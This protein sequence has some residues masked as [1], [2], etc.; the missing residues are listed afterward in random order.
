MSNIR[1]LFLP[2]LVLVA[3]LSQFSIANVHAAAAPVLM[4]D[5]E[6]DGTDS[7]GNYNHGI[8]SGS[9][10]F[11]INGHSGK[12]LSLSGAG[13]IKLP[14]SI[15]V[16]NQ[17]FT[18]ALWFKTTSRG[19][20][21]GYQNVAVG[22]GTATNFIPIIVVTDTGYLRTEIWKNGGGSMIISSPSPVND[23]A[24]HRVV[25]TASTTTGTLAVYLDGVQ[26]GTQT[27]TVD[28]LDM[29]FN[30]IG[31]VDGR[32]RT[33][34][35]NGWDYFTGHIDEFIFY[36]EAQT[37]T[38]IAKITQSI[39]FPSPEDKFLSGNTAAVSATASSSLPVSFSSNTA[40]ICTVSGT[41]VTFLASGQCRIAANQAGDA[42][43]SPAAQVVRG[44]VVTEKTLVW[45]GL[46]LRS[47]AFAAADS[48]LYTS[49][50]QTNAE[51]VAVDL[52]E[53]GFMDVI[54]ADEAN[55]SIIWFKNVDG[56]TIQRIVISSGAADGAH[57]IDVADLDNDGDLDIASVSWID[58]E[59]AWYEN[60]G[61]ENFTR[62]ITQTATGQ[63]PVDIS[64]ADIDGD[65]W[66]DFVLA[67]EVG[68][69][70]ALHYNCQDVNAAAPCV[71]GFG[72]GNAAGGAGYRGP[73]S[74]P[75]VGSAN[76]ARGVVPVDLDG[77][78]KLDVVA[79]LDVGNQL[80]VYEQNDLDGSGYITW[81]KHIVAT[82]GTAG[83]DV[84][85]ADLDN[86]GDL[87]IIVP[88]KTSAVGSLV[89]YENDA[90]KTLSD[91]GKFT[92]HGVN[93]VARSYVQANVGDADGDG[94]NDILSGVSVGNNHYLYVNDGY[95]NF[96][97]QVVN[98]G[99]GVAKNAVL[100]D[101]DRDGDADVFTSAS[102]R[103]AWVENT[104]HYIAL[105]LMERTTGVGTLLAIDDNG[106]PVT[107]AITGGADSG[108]MSVNVN[109][110]ALSFN[111]APTYL[112]YGD[113]NGDNVYD[114]IVTAT[115]NGASVP[116]RVLVTVKPDTDSDGIP[117]DQDSD[118]D[119][120]GVSDVQEISD[121][122][123]PLDYHSVLDTDGDGVPDAHEGA[124][125]SG[126][127]PNAPDAVDSDGDGISDY[128]EAFP[129]AADA[130]V[131]LLGSNSTALDFN[132][133]DSYLAIAEDNGSLN[134]NAGNK[135]TVAAW[136]QADALGG[137][138]FMK[139]SGGNS[140]DISYT[141]RTGA[142][143]LKMEVG[144]GTNYAYCQIPL[145][146]GA[147]HHVVG[148]Y[149]GSGTPGIYIDGIA[150]AC[151]TSQAA[152]IS[153]LKNVTA[154]P[155]FG[156]FPGFGQYLD[157]RLDDVAIWNVQLN[158]AAIAAIYN[159]GHYVSTLTQNFLDYRS[160]ASL[161]AYW[162]FNEGSGT[163]TD[164]GSMFSNVG[165]LTNAPAWVNN[166]AHTLPVAENTTAVFDVDA[167][168]ADGDTLSFSIDSGADA[169]KFTINS[170]T[171]VLSFITAPDY[172][173][174]VDTGADNIY[175]LVIAVTA[176][177]DTVTAAVTVAVTDIDDTTDSDG[178]GLPDYYDPDDDN[179]GVPDAQEAIDGTD[180]LNKL[181]YKDSDGDY[182]P[183]FVETNNDFTNPND[184]ADYKDSD[185][186]G[187][188][189]QVEPD[190]CIFE[191]FS[192]AGTLDSSWQVLSGTTYTPNIITYN[193]E[194][195][196]RLTSTGTGLVSG[197]SKG[198]P[199][200]ATI[201]LRIE[202]K[203]ATYGGT[204]ADGMSVIL[205]NYAVSP[206]LGDSGG[207]LGYMG[208]TGFAGGWLGIG[209]SE[210]PSLFSNSVANA[211]ALRGSASTF[212][213]IAGTGT[214]SPTV[215]D[216]TG[217]HGYRIN[218]VPNSGATQA[219]IKVERDTG[220]GYGTLISAT[221]VLAAS[222]Q[223]ALPA[224]F[225]LSF[226]GSTGGSTN[227]HEITRLRVFAPG[228]ASLYSA[229]S[230]TGTVAALGDSNADFTVSLS[231][232]VGTGESVSVDYSTSN[233]DALA[234]SE[235]T[236]TSGTLTFAPGEQVKTVSV[237]LA[238]L[239]GDNGKKFY[240]QL[241]NQAG[242]NVTVYMGNANAAATIDTIDTD[243]D[244]IVNSLDNDDDNDGLS[245][246]LEATYGTDPLNTDTDGDG[247]SDS[248]EI[249]QGTDPLNAAPIIAQSAPLT[250]TMDED[251][252]PTAWSAPTVSATDTD[253]DILSWSVLH[254]P[255]HG[256]AS[257]SGSGASP[258]TFNYTPDADYSGTDYF[259]IVVTDGKDTDSITVKVTV[260]PM[261]DGAVSGFIPYT[262]GGKPVYDHEGSSD[263]T[264]GGAAVQP[265]AIDIASC[266]A[267]GA[268]P[269]TKPS[270][271]IAYRDTDK[272]YTTTGDAQLV[273]RMRLDTNPSE[274]GRNGSG[275]VS[276]HWDFLIDIDNDGSND[277]IIDVDGGYASNRLDRVVLYADNNHNL[278]IDGGEYVAE[279]P[280]AGTNASAAQQA[281]SAVTITEDASVTCGRSH[282]FWLDIAIPVDSFTAPA[283][284][285]SVPIGAF[286]STSASNTDPLQKDLMGVRDGTSDT[287][288]GLGGGRILPASGNITGTVYD[289]VDGNR[290]YDE[291]NPDSAL[292]MQ[293]V[294][295]LDANGNLVTSYSAAGN[296]YLLSGV[297]PGNYRIRNVNTGYTTT[298]LNVTVVGNENSI[299][300]IPTQGVNRLT[301]YVF[302]DLDGDGA[303]D[304]G[305]PDVNGS[306]IYLDGT[307]TGANITANGSLSLTLYSF[308]RHVVS[309]HAL[310]AGYISTSAVEVAINHVA[311][312]N[313]SV[314]F[315]VTKLGEVS[316]VVYEDK[317][318]DTV[319]DGNEN[320]LAGALISIKDE[321]D[322]LVDS[323]TTGADGSYRFTGL[324]P[325]T[326]YY[327]EET[328]PVGYASTSSD[329][330]PVS[331]G[332]GSTAIIN[333]G[334]VIE[335]RISGFV[336]SDD[337]GNGNDDNGEQGIG[338]VTITLY[339]NSNS[340]IMYG[341]TPYASGEIITAVLT[342]T[343][344]Y[345]SV[346]LPPGR[347]RVEEQDPLNY[348]SVSANS[349]T[350][351]LPSSQTV[352]NFA[353][354]KQ[355]VL[356]GM[357]FND[358][359]GNGQWDSGEP[360]V[361]GVN[362]NIDGGA[363][364]TATESDGSFYFGGLGD[365]SYT[366]NAIVPIGFVA[367]TATALPVTVST[368][369]VNTGLRFGIKISGSIAGEVYHDINGN[370][371]HDVGEVGIGGVTIALSGSAASATTTT[372]VNGL[373]SFSGLTA[374]YAYT[375]TETDPANYKSI[376]P[377]VI[378]VSLD[379]N[380]K[381]DRDASFADRF[382]GIVSGTVFDDLDG[383]ASQ[384]SGERGLTGITLNLTGHTAVVTDSNGNYQFV[385]VSG[386]GLSLSVTVPA[387]YAVTTGNNPTTIDMSSYDGNS[388]FGLQP[389]GSVLAY[390]FNDYNHNGIKDDEDNA[391][392]GVAINLASGE[393][394]SSGSD[395][396]A[397]INDVIP[398]A[399]TAT[400]AGVAGYTNTTD[401]SQSIVVSAG[402]T[403]SVYFG[404]YMNVAPWVRSEAITIPE[405]TALAT[406]LITL[407][408]GD[409]NGDGLTLSI[410]GGNAAGRFS[411]DAVTGEITLVG[412]LD[413]ETTTSYTLTVQAQDGGG[414]TG[415]AVVTITIT[416]VN[417]APVA[418][419][420]S[421]TTLEDTAKAITLTAG[422]VDNDPLSYTVV[423]SPAHGV[424][425]GSAPNVSY[426]PTA[427]YAGADSFTFKVN[428]G[429]LDSAV[430]T[431]S[432]TVI[433]VNDA[434]LAVDDS[435]SVNED[436]AVT[437]NILS[438]DS[439]AENALNAASILIM[440]QPAHGTLSIDPATGAVTYTPQANYHGSDSFQYQVSDANGLSS[441]TATVSITVASVN[442]APVGVNDV[443]STN[444]DTATLP[445]YL[446]ANDTDSDGDSLDPSS[447]VVVQ[448]PAH[449]L[450][451]SISSG[452]LKYTPAS[453]YVGND[454]LQY[455]IKDTNGATSNVTTVYLTVIG[456]N[457]AP[458]AVNDSAS[459]NEDS[460]VL[461]AVVAND[462]DV[463]DGAPDA[464]TVTIV[465]QPAHGTVSVNAVTGGVTYTP[466]GNF[467][468]T[469]S[470]TYMVQDTGG[471]NPVEPAIFS[472][473][474]TVTI[475][476][477]SVN[478]APAAVD[479]NVTMVEDGAPLA[480][481]ILG[482]DSDV[483]GTL[484]PASVTI[485]GAA[486]NGTVIVNATTGRVS[487]T[488]A[489]NFN[490][491]DSF[492]YTVNDDLGLTSNLAT[493]TVSISAVNDAPLAD[494]QS[495]T[496]AED[497]ALPITL[498]A[499]DAEN[500]PLTF[501]VVTSPANG[502]LSGSAPN[503]T[504]TPDA[505]YTGSDS[506]TFS[507]NDGSGDAVAATISITVTPVN[508]APVAVDDA[509]A[510]NE[511][512]SV[513]IAIL[514]NDSDAEN[515]LNPASVLI[516]TP[517]LHGTL[518]ISTAT[519][520]VLYT[521]SANYAGSDSFQ[522]QVSDGAGLS[523]N[524]ATVSIAVTPVN[525]APVGINDVVTTN[526]DTALTPY[527]VLSNDTD[528][529]DALNT[530]SVFVVTPPAHADSYSFSNGVL[531]Y[532]PSTNYVGNDQLQ[533][534]VEDSAG[535][536]SNVTTVY[537]TVIGVN[538]PPV[539]NDDSASTD[540][541]T[542]V[543]I[544]IM[545]N[546]SD[547]EDG[548]P[549]ATT[550]TIVQQP[551]HGAL[552]VHATTGVATYTPD[553]Q[554][555][556]G[557]MFTYIVKDTGNVSPAE[558]PIYSN[559]ASV[560]ITVNP[561]NDA[562]V[563]V[564]DNVTMLEDAL[565]LEINVLGNDS[566]V[567]GT[568]DTTSV[569]IVTPTTMGSLNVDA[570]TG[571]V[572]YT[573]SA[574]FYGTDSFTY[575]VNDDLALVSNTATVTI[576]V[577]AFNDPPL[578]Y[579]NSITTPE[580]TAKAFTLVAV[581]IEGDSIS[582]NL[583]SEPAYGTVTGTAPN[584]VYTPYADYH[585]SDSLTF[586]VNDGVQ[587]STTATV[588]IT[589]TPIN[590]A[591]S[592]LNQS[593]TTAEDIALSLTLTGSD[594][595]DDT[596]IYTVVAAPAHGSL[597]GS[598]PSL[599][600][601]PNAGY[602]GLDSFTF[603]VND[604][605]VDSATATV[606]ITVTEVN[607]APVAVD[608][609][610]LT[611][612]GNSVVI[613][614]LANDSDPEATVLTL[615]MTT[616]PANG[617]LTVNGD[618]TITYTP[619]AGFAG[620]DSFIYTVMDADGQTS[621]AIVFI[622]VM[623]LPTITLPADVYVDAK[624]LFTKVDLGTAVAYDYQGKPLPVS[625]V[626]G[627]TFFWPGANAA[628]WQATDAY[629]QTSFA[630]Q[631]VNVRPLVSFS[632]DQTIAEGSTVRVKVVLNGPS[633]TYPV[634]VSYTVSG[635]AE[636]PADHDLTSGVAVIDSGTETTIVINTVA[637]GIAEGNETI[638][639]TMDDPTLNQ[640][641]HN[642]HT[643]IIS[644]DNIAP[645]VSMDVQQ[646]TFDRLT[647]ALGDGPV[648]VSTTV[649]DPNLGDTHSYDWSLSNNVLVDLDGDPTTFTFDPSSLAAGVYEVWVEV[650]DNGVPAE[651]N[652]GRVFINVVAALP[653]LGSD[654]SDHDG[655]PDDVE[656]F[657][658]TDRDG[659]PDYLDSIPECNVLI[660]HGLTSNG[661]LIE[662]DPGV[663]M[664]IG[665]YALVGE[666]GGAEL[667]DSDIAANGADALIPDSEATN[668]G[669]IF[670]FIVTQVPDAGQSVNIVLPQRNAIP[671]AA[672]YRKLNASGWYTFVEDERNK[673]W[674]T[675]GEQGYCPPPGSADYQPGLT[676][677]DWCVQLTIE[678]GGPNDADGVVNRMIVDPGGVG[679]LNYSTL[680]LKTKGGGALGLWALLVMF[681]LGMLLPGV[682]LSPA[683]RTV[684]HTRRT[685]RDRC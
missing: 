118:D 43:Y 603:R 243:G 307:D 114:V 404:K 92:A 369:A 139:A 600:Y 466:N 576:G 70:V 233:G 661:Y 639:L 629:G 582:Y 674:S 162:R 667:T 598:A 487:Y 614:P 158:A 198:F 445:L 544:D 254:A 247:I 384:D 450:S 149:G 312:A 560:T 168:D 104:G 585:G 475:T 5:F 354:M 156:Y 534:T 221:D 30:Q 395:G 655:I 38:E 660:E 315:G 222:G 109:S 147:W 637:D 142:S 246:I 181:D 292:A 678:E 151:S 102:D 131:F 173:N 527:N 321:A 26:L 444:E 159:A 538:D 370:G 182:V 483:D 135:V 60:D 604:G 452:T 496:T 245:D 619:N 144:D 165:T 594:P 551:A 308:G 599:V 50:G 663:C 34:L 388:N 39:E 160:A 591:P 465:Q 518:S 429:L 65:G 344:G 183:D 519:G 521:P 457:D 325:N 133:T 587:D 626:D 453:N 264:N 640:G 111:S 9:Y 309:H 460:A 123:D 383:N 66:R 502:S 430:A 433:P 394:G 403:T 371:Q 323:M 548:T 448:A 474:A 410:I 13:Y 136:V 618:G 112:S 68:D 577:T 350:V 23:G 62:R 389:S 96:T 22:G 633:P 46:S 683:L 495:V 351:T 540:E 185:G 36:P 47:A 44:F 202:F 565:P 210:Y 436:N 116:V 622:E 608:D 526:E 575:T 278:I 130:P 413:Y 409:A 249:A 443:I 557:D 509:V 546:D 609:Q 161:R 658:D 101:F 110:G 571:R 120:D 355:G 654:D 48:L 329:L 293:T 24:W 134:L 673:L 387:S 492:T 463:E 677:G 219:W 662:G 195:R 435:A 77:D 459:T 75:E 238:D 411:I 87:D 569:A 352:A 248:D 152:T 361:N 454:Q 574:N 113:A 419:G 10:S 554:Y 562:P 244:G 473:A 311:G 671:E 664:R 291:G 42:T 208:T 225:R 117:D 318:G 283:Y 432:I 203:A 363:P 297:E 220:A 27:S 462:T 415:S 64:L 330:V 418:H 119:N 542:T 407:F 397:R 298:T 570:V 224:E 138:I 187:I 105:A 617:T 74:E 616:T 201:P 417:E 621:T 583:V 470:F 532:T 21:L 372:L 191:N 45:T 550:V 171:G 374:S 573:P 251:G 515:N 18:V 211:V 572:T 129:G 268:S 498:T 421:V 319:K 408:S 143:G 303:Y 511:D 513:A 399:N 137:M 300:D 449:A 426:T 360:G 684:R 428:D 193:G 240:L 597:S 342:D 464:T 314:Y 154:T 524:T 656:G 635:L 282:D 348:V 644:E 91:A 491:S 611:P 427:N 439:D 681:C 269:G 255:V 6:G 52:D 72:F 98:S 17:D 78:G 375:V 379:A 549:N 651:S 558:P 338:H 424:L 51:S 520:S 606:A 506:F 262:V 184:G 525:D 390:V 652:I 88:R 223:A 166:T 295:L 216:S 517:P 263:P 593:L 231:K 99:T 324:S 385:R 76:S 271:M 177:G 327:L 261:V 559:L 441:N 230:V 632:K 157:G 638:I 533:Y 451:Y 317:D 431:V 555:T 523:S 367:T 7:S 93:T 345:Y 553:S 402:G 294:E 304:A 28:H 237:P 80:V 236:A 53:N 665:N 497:T 235:Y 59:L 625:L 242:T 49:T 631:M 288:V 153:N 391:L 484:N 90:T 535:A 115:A 356:T 423:T 645:S 584:L 57:G 547:V 642:T 357:V 668:V 623:T 561:V 212:N 128:V 340:D 232:V 252:S 37:A 83:W 489:A 336:F 258:G 346:S 86:D 287:F 552:S 636:Y 239:T 564:N 378:S 316:G 365:G 556:G 174:P 305:E 199:I 467:H 630:T 188:P 447:L 588:M 3:S 31:V 190:V 227:N 529:D 499:S 106:D 400:I 580:D 266:S 267:N 368:T 596:L 326:K 175:N 29:I 643:I 446:P 15:I 393:S 95:G 438:N 125:Y 207:A 16:N 366:L 425:G 437:I 280:V 285:A 648:V 192:G 362:L 270:V 414:L 349:L 320:P 682:R 381:A 234:G 169:A 35:V 401:A 33:G 200:P 167:Y 376:T 653:I 613:S 132:G 100:V 217:G 563:A 20:I 627:V 71:N 647:V 81:T 82:P 541:D 494:P 490:G 500:D 206:A 505:N 56:S 605:V 486:S 480:I 669:G 634:N 145:A 197:V 328:N 306:D 274:N 337:N 666:T 566:D 343:T 215:Q 531:S 272:N 55:D 539:A 41:T 398:G 107:Y 672:V 412:G 406:S 341:G 334:D 140:A 624:G 602:F 286:Y 335:G 469:D 141:L 194:K 364:T 455:T 685:A 680:N 180:P 228:C 581:D 607:E 458:V 592:A 229:V 290:V 620:G 508:D 256:S 189:N 14:D 461:V 528:I 79:I 568:L 468:G 97:E 358:L 333:F 127:N 442:D 279:W 209:I 241:N 67:Y 178:D 259:T 646:N 322:T 589:V 58:S 275:L 382:E 61:S 12:A 284:N 260:N 4:Y 63:N 121:G 434:P 218:Y 586:N 545:A 416:N 11:D 595:D 422:D 420:Q 281:T 670:D 150:V 250:V 578:T 163:S 590:D 380:G 204:G 214:L 146:T 514:A 579:D 392:S 19:G 504:Y 477:N 213:Y 516:I 659:I 471:S 522:Y 89:W 675:A 331:F 103:S 148:T 289:D 2:V 313:H 353:D 296:T 205:S 650:T 273:M 493:V 301:V 373:F 377:N 196:L 543:A 472:N 512:Y 347:Y 155:G 186:D 8:L 299:V 657:A 1:S 94:D 302:E 276:Y 476:V 226:A 501:S 615:V 482:N 164:D 530:A 257:V 396:L 84:S 85:V 479:D 679:V 124:P 277:Y 32:S 440:T 536:V 25:L 339:N 567:D 69:H 478:D 405:D 537:I 176:N 610:V 108:V 126:G 641:V 265:D 481:N 122:S 386:D 179:D 503:L 73:A 510:V 40:G 170:A 488:P 485:V 310:P 359:N 54:A 456:V 253:A 612:M 507:A 628:V 649:T 332:T 172:E 676:P 601:T